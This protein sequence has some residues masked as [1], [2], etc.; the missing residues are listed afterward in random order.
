MPRRRSGKK[1]D[2]T[3]WTYSSAAFN[4]QGAGT[5]GVNMAAAQHLSETLLRIRG[6]FTCFTDGALAPGVGVFAGLGLILVPEGT[7][8][9][10]TWSPITDGD[11][12][13]IWV[14]YF[15]MAYEELV[16]DVIANQAA[17]AMRRVIDNKAMRVIRNQEIQAVVENVTNQGAMNISVGLQIRV[18]AGT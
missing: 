8:T 4:G 18:L 14:D 11:A 9:T 1:I 2:F 13:W 6:E 10:V 3:H 16:V 7:G 12:P 15:T 17:L 5:A